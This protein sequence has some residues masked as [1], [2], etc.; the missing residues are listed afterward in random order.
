MT[1]FKHKD[2][3]AVVDYPDGTALHDLF[4][5]LDTW[6]TVTD[7]D[8]PSEPAQTEGDTVTGT[9]DA[10]DPDAGEPAGEDSQEATDGGTSAPR[11]R[12]NRAS[13]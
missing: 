8:E 6:V 11:R 7:A 13:A 9:P 5:R 3:G 10:G 1:V 4:T 2:T 12:R